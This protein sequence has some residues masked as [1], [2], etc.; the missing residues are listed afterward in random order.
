MIQ[1]KLIEMTELMEVLGYTDERT[2]TKWCKAHNIPIFGFGSKK[3]TVSNFIEIFLETEL[4]KFLRAKYEK[5]EEILQAIKSDDK[6]ELAKLAGV[7]VAR[8]VTKRFEAKKVIS[9][10]AEAFLKKL[11]SA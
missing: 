2:V 3:Y 9:K 6:V 4:R 10:H 7:P 8:V 11:K 1:D 5:A